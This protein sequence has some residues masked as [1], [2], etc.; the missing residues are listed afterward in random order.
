MSESHEPVQMPGWTEV[1]LS[2]LA[3]PAAFA[4]IALYNFAVAPAICQLGFSR[5][6]LFVVFSFAIAAA[7]VGVGLVGVYKSYRNHIEARAAGA[8]AGESR[9]FLSVGG[10]L[11]SVVFTGLTIIA[12]ISSLAFAPCRPV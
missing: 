7:G 12:G 5:H 9:R 1:R 10:I 8:E 6:I 4:V 11:L 2:L 3:P